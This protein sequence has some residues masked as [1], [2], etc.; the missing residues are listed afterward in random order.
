MC[1]KLKLFFNGKYPTLENMEEK[2]ARVQANFRN[3]VGEVHDCWFLSKQ[4]T[5]YSSELTKLLNS[6]YKISCLDD[7]T[8]I[9]DSDYFKAHYDMSVLR[10]DHYHTNALH[11]ILVRLTEKNVFRQS[12]WTEFIF[13]MNAEEEGCLV[14]RYNLYMKEYA[15]LLESARIKWDESIKKNVCCGADGQGEG[16]KA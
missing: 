13:G 16:T 3:L 8:F 15:E 5:S 4:N 6:Y 9:L 2:L 12:L 7:C 11:R 10:T 14:D 1:I